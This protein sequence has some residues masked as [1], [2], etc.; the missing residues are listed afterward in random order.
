MKKRLLAGAAVLVFLL[1]AALLLLISRDYFHDG[2]KAGDPVQSAS[3]PAPASKIRVVLG[4]DERPGLF[5]PVAGWKGVRDWLPNSGRLV[6]P[7][8]RRAVMIL[9]EE[10]PG[11]QVGVAPT[12]PSVPPVVSADETAPL[13][14]T[15]GTIPH[16]F[17]FFSIHLSSH[18]AEI[19]AIYENYRLLEQGLST[20]H[21]EHRIDGWTW[22]RVCL[23]F[24][25]T[26]DRAAREAQALRGQGRIPGY[27]IVL[28]ERPRKN[29]PRVK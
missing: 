25:P 29:P 28:V 16:G 11:G 20:F 18:I 6:S 22:F 2:G 7:D 24:F 13:A 12:Q 23:G 19:E 10:P 21:Y 3:R 1:V 17:N 8:Y 5:P 15:S 14:V 26:Y 27:R 4:P 9:A